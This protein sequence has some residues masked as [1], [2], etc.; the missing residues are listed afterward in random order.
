MSGVEWRGWGGGS[1]GGNEVGVAAAVLVQQA[2]GGGGLHARM[3][4]QCCTII[5]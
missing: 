5:L 3:G 2:S 4:Q 1:W